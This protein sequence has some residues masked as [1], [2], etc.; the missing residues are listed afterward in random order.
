MKCFFG[1]VISG[2]ACVLAAHASEPVA[3]PSEAPKLEAQPAPLDT[4]R[5]AL[6]GLSEGVQKD[7]SKDKPKRDNNLDGE[8][9]AKTEEVIEQERRDWLKVGVLKLAGDYK[10]ESELT[11]EEQAELEERRQSYYSPT[12][13]VD[14]YA[15]QQA[16][17][18]HLP[19]DDFQ[20]A[21]AHPLG[22]Q[23]EDWALQWSA[24]N[25]PQN[26]PSFEPRRENPYMQDAKLPTTT[27]IGDTPVTWR[28]Q[29]MT[30][31]T[32]YDEVQVSLLKNRDR[33]TLIGNPSLSPAT[34][35]TPSGDLT[36]TRAL[37]IPV[38]AAGG[39]PLL[40]ENQREE[41]YFRAMDRF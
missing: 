4:L 24:S 5:P 28:P 8:P 30:D 36:P 9:T 16:S 29:P 1:S 41:R 40:Q 25:E 22:G 31:M 35:S 20:W 18:K 23:G 10:P 6:E 39:S 3:E 13:F 12:L 21:N 11:E 7:F 38:P 37:S 33:M 27:V 2:F 19:E 32:N 34:L 15:E 17:K 14:H 26:A